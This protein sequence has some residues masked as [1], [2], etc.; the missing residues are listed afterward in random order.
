MNTV[1]ETLIAARKLIEKPE[2]W[3]KGAHARDSEGVDV[4]PD[5]S[6]SVCFCASGAVRLASS[7][8]ALELFIGQKML[9]ECLPPSLGYDQ[10][11]SFNDAP[12]TTHAD[13]LALFDRAIAACDTNEAE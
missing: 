3:T 6:S 11:P 4:W 2:N 13:V 1:K 10:I 12:E 8:S 5:D 9:E 7:G